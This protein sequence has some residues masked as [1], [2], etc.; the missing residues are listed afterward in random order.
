MNEACHP[1]PASPGD[2]GSVVISCEGSERT[3]ASRIRFARRLGA[4]DIV[5]DLG[6]T[7][8]VGSS[9]LSMLY[10]LAREVGV[11]GGRVAVVCLR[12]S[13]ERLLRMTLLDHAF[14]VYGSRE[15]ALRR[16][17]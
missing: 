1:A 13:L 12:P 2:R 7:E 10:G 16:P 3:L 5:V 4:D 8:M 9:T 6:E 15:A 14:A 17:S 11:R